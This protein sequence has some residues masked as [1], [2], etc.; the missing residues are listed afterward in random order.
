MLHRLHLRYIQCII[1]F[2]YAFNVYHCYCLQGYIFL[3]YLYRGSILYSQASSKIRGLGELID[4]FC[5]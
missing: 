1:F 2:L 3:K 5:H 4:E